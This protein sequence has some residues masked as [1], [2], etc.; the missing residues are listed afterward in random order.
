MIFAAQPV[1]MISSGSGLAD[2]LSQ[3]SFLTADRARTGPLNVGVGLGVV[4]Y[5]RA[6]ST[7][8][9][10][11]V[12]DPIQNYGEYL[13]VQSH[14]DRLARSENSYNRSESTTQGRLLSMNRGS[15]GTLFTLRAGE[16]RGL[17]HLPAHAD[18]A[19]AGLSL[20]DQA[21]LTDDLVNGVD[22]QRL[23]AAFDAEQT[24]SEF[25]ITDG[26]LQAG[27]LADELAGVIS[28]DYHELMTSVAKEMAAVSASTSTTDFG[29]RMEQE[30]ESVRTFLADV[31]ERA[32]RAAEAA[33]A[34]DDDD[35]PTVTNRPVVSETPTGQNQ[36]PPS[37]PEATQVIVAALRHDRVIERLAPEVTNSRFAEI[38]ANAE[39]DA[40]R[41]G[42]SF[43]PSESSR[44]RSGFRAATLW[45]SPVWRMHSLARGCAW[46]RGVSLRHL[47][48]S[49]PEMID[50]RYSTSLLPER[51]RLDELAEI[52]AFQLEENASAIESAL[53]LAYIG[54]Q[55]GQ[56]ELVRRGIEWMEAA[57]A[58]DPLPVILR[59]I[60]LEE[61]VQQRLDEMTGH[62]GGDSIVD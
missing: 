26:T 53:I 42:S 61:D 28:A 39:S 36:V 60:W 51:E 41:P 20:Y 13:G 33:E 48:T 55:T 18:F 37:V 58:K 44:G 19:M 7:V 32:Q 5:R 30:L 40:Y 29:K 43:G 34:T 17:D 2:A 52:V 46:R 3:L 25:Q 54:H 47:F 9:L 49:H 14:L 57:D 1:P 10:G 45:R 62:S 56:E 35:R 16:M 59:G 15:D 21:R 31:D 24:I 23:G 12:T 27:P 4:E 38:M 8:D 50:T 22:T 6:S 11:S